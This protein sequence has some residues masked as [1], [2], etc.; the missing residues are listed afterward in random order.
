MGDIRLLAE[1][2]QKSRQR[3]GMPC[4][5][6]KVRETEN[7]PLHTIGIVVRC[8][9]RSGSLRD[10]A[11]IY[12]SHYEKPPLLTKLRYRL[13]VRAIALPRHHLY[14]FSPNQD[15]QHLRQFHIVQFEAIIMRNENVIF[16]LR[17]SD[18]QAIK[19]VLMMKGQIP[20]YFINRQGRLL[21]TNRI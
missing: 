10:R 6:S 2:S 20:Q 21:L 14:Q 5:Q 3:Q 8:A 7:F 12:L 9:P 4:L 1:V 17:L 13:P 15:K 18:N 16:C 19:R 11:K